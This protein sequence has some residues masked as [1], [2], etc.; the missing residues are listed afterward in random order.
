V[1]R[2]RRR[3]RPSRNLSS[4]ATGALFALIVAGGAALRWV[5]LG[6][7]AACLREVREELGLGTEANRLL[8]V[9]YESADES[10]GECLKFI[11][12][13]G[14]LSAA[15]LQAIR[16]DRSE[17]EEFRFVSPDE[18]M[19]KLDARLAR[20]LALALR[21]LAQDGTVYAEDGAESAP[22]TTMREC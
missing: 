6:T 14:V 16:L 21:A 18:A 5:H 15:Q 7:R 3:L 2:A 4:V 12:F 1:A 11:F 19:A 8:C 17:I 10:H 13:G 9:E 20:R 22:D